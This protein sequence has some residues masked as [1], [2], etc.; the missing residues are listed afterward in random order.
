MF[1]SRRNKEVLRSVTSRLRIFPRRTLTPPSYDIEVIPY[2]FSHISLL[3]DEILAE[4][5]ETTRDL[6]E[7]DA[8]DMLHMRKCRDSP[9]VPLVVSLVC[10]Q[11]RRVSFTHPLLWSHL[12]ISPPWT[13]GMI[14]F[15]LEKSKSCPL[16]LHFMAHIAD[17]GP[18]RRRYLVGWNG[19]SILTEDW[20][21]CRDLALRSFPSLYH[22]LFDHLPRCRSITFHVSNDFSAIISRFIEEFNKDP[23]VLP[24]LHRFS[25]QTQSI[26]GRQS[27]VKTELFAK[28]GAPRLTDVNMGY[29]FLLPS[30]SQVTSLHIRADFFTFAEFWKIMPQFRRLR[31]LALYDDFKDHWPAMGQGLTRSLVCQLPSLLSLHFY[32]FPHISEFLLFVTAPNLRD[33]VMGSVRRDSLTAFYEQQRSEGER[34]PL[35]RTITMTIHRESGALL[36]YGSKCFPRVEEATIYGD[37]IL[38]T[39]PDLLAICDEVVWPRLGALAIIGGSRS[40][41]GQEGQDMLREIIDSRDAEGVPLRKI[42]LDPKVVGEMDA[43]FVDWLKDSVELVVKD[44]WKDTRRG[45]LYYPN[46]SFL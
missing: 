42:W 3:P 39:L 32:N 40:L 16:H 21:R 2:T 33:L 18:G 35:L 19:S 45:G 30:F 17:R 25:L 31:L 36:L 9:R 28:G 15:W 20:T 23:A 14:R 5:F 7:V 41:S 37:N 12:N 22:I 6:A 26:R 8:E 13:L 44:I 43:S 11:W 1:K 38:R 4:I 29:P 34:F 10:S 24:L 46:R 27:I